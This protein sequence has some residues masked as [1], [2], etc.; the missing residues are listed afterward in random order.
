VSGR[1]TKVCD[2]H[3]ECP[4]VQGADGRAVRVP[5]RKIHRWRWPV[6]EET[7]AYQLA[8]PVVQN[9]AL[10]WLGAEATVW[11]NHPAMMTG[12]SQVGP[13]RRRI[14]RCRLGLVEGFAWAVARLTSPKARGLWPLWNRESGRQTPLLERPG[15]QRVEGGGKKRE[16]GITKRKPL[17][18]HNSPANQ[19]QT[20][21]TNPLKSKSMRGN[22]RVGEVS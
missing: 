14:T 19:H 4:K 22:D 7:R 9:P 10:D 3:P 13:E 8:S 16:E 17:P 20:E 1:F 15:E 21:P 18:K 5:G 6:S 12:S 2:P 11:G